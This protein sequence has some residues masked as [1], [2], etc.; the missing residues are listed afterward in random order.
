M[1]LA[2]LSDQE[3]K[4]TLILKERLELL[5]KQQ[6]CQEYR[7]VLIYRWTPNFNHKTALI[8]SGTVKSEYIEKQINQSVKPMAENWSIIRK[9]LKIV[10]LIASASGRS[11]SCAG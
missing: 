11:G 10:Q 3:I 5:K 4:E 1:N 9:N 6:G 2:H 7:D 8:L